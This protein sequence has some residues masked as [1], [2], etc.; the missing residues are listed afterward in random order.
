MLNGDPF[1]TGTW[2]LGHSHSSQFVFVSS[3]DPAL[4]VTIGLCEPRAPK[5]HRQ[6][7]CPRHRTTASAH[8]PLPQAQDPKMQA[9]ET[10]SGTVPARCAALRGSAPSISPLDRLGRGSLL[11]SHALLHFHNCSS[12]ALA[13][14]PTTGLELLQRLRSLSNAESSSNSPDLAAPHHSLKPWDA[15]STMVSSLMKL[16]I[17]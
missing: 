13:R 11:R 4:S 10:K 16:Q 8:P 1:W 14:A 3:A 6:T 17:R 2:M 15:K 5:L 7:V 12:A 9:A